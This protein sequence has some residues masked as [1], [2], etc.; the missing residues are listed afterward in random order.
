MGPKYRG[1]K[2]LILL[3]KMPCR[4]IYGNY[5]KVIGSIIIFF[6][7]CN[8]AAEILAGTIRGKIKAQRGIRHIEY[9]VVYIENIVGKKFRSPQEHLFMD[10]RELRFVPHILPILVGSTVDFLNSDTV[11][12]NVFTPDR[13]ADSFNLGTYG[14]GGVRSYTFKRIGKVVVLCNIHPEMEGFVVVLQNPYFTMSERRGRFVIPDVPAGKYTLK[15]WHKKAKDT[16]I[17]VDVPEEGYI[18]VSL[19]LSRK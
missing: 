19:T 3:S 4:F 18:D 6:L 11:K 5:I 13:I 12:H 9:T 7:G 10:Q 15:A 17:F 1:L 14:P 16:S 8:T 2:Y